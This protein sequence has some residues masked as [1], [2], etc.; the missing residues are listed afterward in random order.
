[1]DL[2]LYEFIARVLEELIKFLEDERDIYNATR[3]LTD[4]ISSVSGDNTDFL[5][6]ISEKNTEI[7]SDLTTLISLLRILQNKHTFAALGLEATIVGLY[8][9]ECIDTAAE[10]LLQENQPDEKTQVI[11]NMTSAFNEAS[12]A[13]TEK[14]QEAADDAETAQ[15]W[16][17]K[18][19]D[20]VN[21]DG[22]IKETES[23]GELKKLIE[24]LNDYI[25][26]TAKIEVKD[27]KIQDYKYLS[28][29][30]NNMESIIEKSLIA[31]QMSCLQ[32]CYD[33]ASTAIPGIKDELQKAETEFNA[34]YTD[35]KDKSKKYKE[36]AEGG[37]LITNSDDY[38][39]DTKE[40][41]EEATE[42]WVSATEQ[43][44]ALSILDNAYESMADRYENL[45]HKFESIKLSPLSPPIDT[46]EPQDK[47]PITRDEFLN[48]AWDLIGH[49]TNSNIVGNIAAIVQAAIAANTP[50]AAYVSPAGNSSSESQSGCCCKMDVNKILEGLNKPISITINEEE[51]GKAAIRYAIKQS[52]TFGT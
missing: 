38:I 19:Q 13:A 35:Y 23:I 46:Y 21:Q 50:A 36:L 14:M 37:P 51:I 42:R 44:F 17:Q 49:F 22:S 32:D 33:K 18:I 31:A 41:Y 27:N 48:G 10:I 4:A 3:G 24:Y 40:Q 29:N 20:S 11:M 6:D 28:N 2:K 7:S 9:K 34:A 30:N 26:E 43:F 45:A 16:W 52:Q 47:A 39:L 15:K 8:G 5:S 1:M 12:Q 25:G